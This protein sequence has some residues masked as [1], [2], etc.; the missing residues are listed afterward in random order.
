M[1]I[2]DLPG[3][4]LMWVLIGSEVAVF[5]AGITVMEAVRLTD[6]AGFATAQGML[7]G[8][9][10]TLNTALLV[11]S[12]LFAAR[13]ERDGGRAGLLLAA[14]G[15]VAFLAVKIAEYTADAARGVTMEAHPFFTFYYLLTGFHAAHVI[16][17]VVVLVLVAIRP[18]RDTAQAAAMFWH[19][20]DLVWVLLLAPVYL[21]G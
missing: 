10:A 4:L 11:T 20:V 1:R 21:L 14:L 8:R 3:E 15:G 12:G 13:A 17:G 18:R 2:D 5:A 19:M 6:P 7:D 16:A 9:M